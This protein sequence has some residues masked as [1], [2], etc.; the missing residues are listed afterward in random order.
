MLS[1]FVGLARNLA[2]I[3]LKPPNLVVL[4]LDNQQ[5]MFVGVWGLN[6]K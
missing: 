6:W 5:F 1:L 2:F 3:F 4:K